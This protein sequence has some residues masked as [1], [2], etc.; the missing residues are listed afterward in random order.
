MLKKRSQEKE[1]IDLGAE[2][3]THDEYIQCLKKLFFINKFLGFFRSTVNILKKFSPHST[4]LDV[5]CGDGLFILNLSQSF[6]L[7]KMQGIDIS[8]TA[9][10]EAQ[11]TLNTWKKTKPNLPVCFRWRPSDQLDIAENSFDIILL[12]LVCHH[13]QDDDLVVFLRQIH[14]AAGQAVIIND[15]HR[16]R[17]SYILY[18]FLSPL[19]LKNRLIIHDGLVSIRR[20]FIRS[21]WKL[22]LNKAGIKHYQLKWRLPFRWQ[23]I[24][25]KPGL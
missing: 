22:L 16:H 18:K 17:L 24:L 12:T 8:Q 6:P 3:Y 23:L 10:D 5:G 20:G 7:M 4:L 2:Y 25:T 15:L 21:E 19:L 1:L 13:L 11:Q 9:I 14:A